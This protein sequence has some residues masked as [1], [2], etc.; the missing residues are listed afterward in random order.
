MSIHSKVSRIISSTNK[1]P[2]IVNKNSNFVVV[3][4][5]W[6]SGKLNRN[7]AR[8]CTDFYETHLKQI[9]KY[10]ISIISSTS[11]SNNIDG[12]FRTLSTNK[13]IYKHIKENMLDDFITQTYENLKTDNIKYN[14]QE[15]YA[16]LERKLNILPY[17]DLLIKLSKIVISSILKNKDNLVKLYNLNKHFEVL[18]Q[19][20]LS[21]K[22]NTTKRNEQLSIEREAAVAEYK[23]HNYMLMQLQL[24]DMNRNRAQEIPDAIIKKLQKNLDDKEF[25]G[26]LNTAKK[27][28]EQK[29]DIY[30]KIIETLKKKDE[31][32]RPDAD[33]KNT[34]DLIIEAL[35]YQPP[36]HFETMIDAWESSCRENGCNYLSVEYPE[37]T[38]K[39]GYQLAINAKPKFIKKA[40]ELCKGYGVLYIDG[41][42]TIRKYPGI[43]DM[44]SVDYMAR[45]WY[46]DPRSSWKM[47]ESITYDP[48]DFETS[49]GTMFFSSSM[50][51]G[52]LL[53]LWIW[54]A[55]K[56]INDG[57]ADDRVLSLVF[58]TQAA[59]TWCRIIQ[60]PVE[61]LW[62]TLDYDDR[63]LEMVYYNDKKLMDSTLLIDHPEC[64]TSEDTATGGAGSGRQPKFG[65]FMEDTY[66]CVELT[67]EHITFKEL[68]RHTHFQE[69][70][71]T[72]DRNVPKYL[73]YF[74][75]YYYYMSDLQYI[76]DGNPYLLEQHFVN[77]DD[78]TENEYPLT[79][80]PH[81]DKY[82]NIKHPINKSITLN[83]LAQINTQASKLFT[84]NHA[85]LT[86]Y[87]TH[88]EIIPQHIDDIKRPESIQQII[89]L[90]IK[91]PEKPIIYNPTKFTGYNNKLYDKIINNMDSLYKYIDFAFNPIHEVSIHRGAFYKPHINL[92]QPVLI[93]YDTRLIDYL[94]MQTSL[95]DLSDYIQRG[96]YQFMSLV[97]IAYVIKPRISSV[98]SGGKHK[99]NSKI[100]LLMANYIQTFE[101]SFRKLLGSKAKKS[102]KK[103]KKNTKYKNHKKISKTRKRSNKNKT[104]TKNKK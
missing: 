68:D 23:L 69:K 91:Y 83:Q 49:G 19:K 81:G 38:E 7:T 35:E 30:V 64:L 80:I 104:K 13:A 76:N 97:R 71:S 54:A 11:S 16:F 5:W 96:S 47:E 66:P 3:T 55:E 14:K 50:A 42:M 37:F 75:W 4:Y 25:D 59:L 33:A 78:P 93:R 46:V 6:G 62:L 8:P 39:G 67:H 79:V 82:G 52:K 99:T 36:I 43:F 94:L 98:Q 74:F 84:N 27:F 86:E 102:I 24:P 87:D 22:T 26:L 70:I 45:G 44:K 41:D 73:P 89:G 28:N 1:K 57:K 21:L 90:L 103:N 77:P 65:N 92:N 2:T 12:I 61:Y 15:K 58:N 53:D 95:D 51:A 40:L 88:F 56:P 85:N 31:F 34:F 17:E 101:T 29:D 9:N 72:T 63:M 20:Y 32:L 10:V 48:Y 100:G 18:R 60:L